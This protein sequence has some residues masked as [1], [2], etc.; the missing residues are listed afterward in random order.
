[1]IQDPAHTGDSRGVHHAGRWSDGGL[2][3]LNGPGQGGGVRD[4]AD[5]GVQKRIAG[6]SGEASGIAVDGHYPVP[7]S[8]VAEGEMPTDATGGPRHENGA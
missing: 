1:L 8:G 3:L 7:A 6:E 5:E 4:I 2:R